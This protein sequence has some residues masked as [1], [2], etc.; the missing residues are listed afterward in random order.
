MARITLVD[1]ARVLNQ[2]PPADSSRAIAGV[3]ALA[4]AGPH[5]VAMITLRCVRKTVQ[6]YAIANR[7][8]PS[9]KSASREPTKPSSK[10]DDVEEAIADVLTLFAPPRS[11]RP[12]PGIDPSARVAKS[13]T[14]GDGCALGPN[15]I[16]GNNTTLGSGV[17]LHARRGHRG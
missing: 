16:I 6:P 3:A 10:V 14:L 8:S 1:I 4:D 9:E 13:A 15:V 5:D 11:Q 12:Q 17:A 2:P 7:H